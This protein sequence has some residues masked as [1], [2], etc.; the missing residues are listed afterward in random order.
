[1]P[2]TITNRAEDLAKGLFTD[3]V[4]QINDDIR[5]NLVRIEKAVQF[6]VQEAIIN[7]RTTLELLNPDSLLVGFL[8]HP[9]PSK[10][11]EDVAKTVSS[12]VYIS[13]KRFRVISARTVRGAL[14]I[15][16]LRDDLKEALTIPSAKYVTENGDTL[17]IMEA[18]LLNG[19]RVY[20]NTLLWQPQRTLSG[21]RT[22]HAIMLDSQGKQ[23]FLS[24]VPPEH[25]GTKDNNWLTRAIRTEQ[26]YSFLEDTMLEYIY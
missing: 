22:G 15:G 11:V 21:S 1:M 10:I 8:G 26:F 13:F 17:P 5:K 2:V 7:D 24:R 3:L 23:F 9:A 19:D 16:V 18:M 6:R 20:S 12:N 25:S 4:E 14:D